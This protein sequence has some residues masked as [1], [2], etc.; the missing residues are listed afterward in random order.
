MAAF[1]PRLIRD[2]ADVLDRAVVVR[3]VHG[4]FRLARNLMCSYEQ[5]PS[6]DEE[7][8]V[9]I[10]HNRVVHV[11]EAGSEGEGDRVQ[12]EGSRRDCFGLVGACRVR[13]RVGVA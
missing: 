9:R 7:R 8:W 2:R 1:R 4:R 3:C 11:G 13:C 12:S 6:F 5:V 10:A